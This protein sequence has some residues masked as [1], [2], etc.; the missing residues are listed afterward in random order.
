VSIA[1]SKQLGT[2]IYDTWGLPVTE[3]TDG[4][5]PSTAAA[6]L[7]AMAGEHAGL[8]RILEYRRLCKAAQFY[9]GLFEHVDAGGRVHTTSTSWAP[10]PGAGAAATRTCS[11]SPRRQRTRTPRSCLWHAPATS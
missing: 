2:L 5:A 10:S 9:D 7:E 8:D 11:R 4:G 6:V 3:R 1:S